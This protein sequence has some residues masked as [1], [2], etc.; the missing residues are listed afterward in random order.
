MFRTSLSFVLYTSPIE[1]SLHERS[2][3]SSMTNDHEFNDPREKNMLPTFY[4]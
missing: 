3:R 1:T 2:D 4:N